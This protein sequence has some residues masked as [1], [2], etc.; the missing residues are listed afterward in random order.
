M[1]GLIILY[2]LG[3]AFYD[4]ATLHNKKSKWIYVVLGI[5]SYYFFSFL[6]GILIALL[7]DLPNNPDAMSDTLLGLL[8]VP[9]ALFFTLLLYLFLKNRWERQ[10]LE[11][12]TD[13]LDDTFI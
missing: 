9:F 6:A 10:P 5:L 7:A 4:L 13:L 8:A 2:G 1:L 3:K 11:V 12:T